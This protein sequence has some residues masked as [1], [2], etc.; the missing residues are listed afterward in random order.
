[1]YQESVS[2]ALS[3]QR[4]IPR[5]QNLWVL[6]KPNGRCLWIPSVL[7]V[8]DKKPGLL[9]CCTPGHLLTPFP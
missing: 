3:K 8:E 9:L 1:M 6:V 5:T 7:Q 2:T 4:P